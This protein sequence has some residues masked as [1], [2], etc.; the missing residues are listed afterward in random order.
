MT[1]FEKFAEFVRECPQLFPNKLRMSWSPTVTAFFY[2]LGIECGYE[3]RCGN[4]FKKLQ[5]IRIS[6]CLDTFPGKYAEVCNSWKVHGLLDIDVAWV[7]HGFSVPKNFG[8]IPTPE[9]A[10][11]LL[12]V[13]HEDESTLY[14]D[15]LGTNFNVVLDEVRKIGNVRTTAKVF[16]YVSSREELE[17]QNH[18]DKLR[19]EIRLIPDSGNLTKHW[20]L[21]GIGKYL[22]P[23]TRKK[24]ILND[25]LRYIF[26]KGTVLDMQGNIVDEKELLIPFPH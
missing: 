8:N 22:A 26:C 21:I 24:P 5:A 17:S 18:V 4:Q 12:S 14:R 23:K 7:P 3:S 13:E 9:R 2:A 19:R 10:E 6:R 15:K 25:S 16:S 1:L 20:L 11:I